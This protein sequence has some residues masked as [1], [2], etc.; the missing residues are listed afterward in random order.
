MPGLVYDKFLIFGDSITEFSY[1]AYPNGATDDTTAHF[2]FGSALQN[3]YTRRLDV[4]QRGYAGF[5]SNHAADM[6]SEIVRIENSGIGKI[7]IATVFFGTNDAVHEGGCQH[8]PLDQFTS[9]IESIIKTLEKSNIKVI[10]IGPALHDEPRWRIGR[11]E[12]YKMGLI[13][14]NESNLKYSTAAKELASSL[15]VPFVDLYSE[16]KKFEK[17]DKWKEL[18][19][20]GVHFT[21]EG[22]K[23]L[24]NQVM[25][26][27]R[28]SY[29][30]LA[31][32]NLPFI[33]PYW[34]D[35]RSD[36]PLTEQ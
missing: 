35:I 15:N 11:A 28:E 24:F 32:E 36:I 12:D 22:Y 2:A 7:K 3:T 6:I 9:N 17:D 23:V 8:V 30:E 19:C 16:F 10:V 34:R 25:A 29:P 13:R 18:L 31:P 4:V 21:G 1:N 20:D 33:L 27:I 14:S 5:N 26:K